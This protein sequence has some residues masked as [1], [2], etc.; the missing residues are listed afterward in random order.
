MK[1]IILQGPNLNLIGVRSAQ[2]GRRTT[3]D[4]INRDLRRTAHELA[5]D[6]TILQ[7]HRIDKAITFIQRNRNTADGLL[8]APMS[9]ARHELT[10]LETLRLVNLPMVEVLL[11][12]DFDFGPAA[13][14]SNYSAFC[15][16]TIIGD[17]ETVF[18]AGLQHLTQ[19]FNA[20]R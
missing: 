16:A 11:S 2:T 3:L 12:R 8:L 4:K 17:P 10:L 14:E 20:D 5:V 9:W 19:V 13:G 1:I 7:T 15:A 18:S 6:I